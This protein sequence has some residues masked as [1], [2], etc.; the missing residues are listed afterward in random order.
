M[1]VVDLLHQPLVVGS[2]PGA[3]IEIKMRDDIAEIDGTV[4]DVASS[5]AMAAGNATASSSPRAWVYCVPLPD[6]PGQFQHLAVSGEGRFDSSTMAP[7]DYRVLAFANRQPNLPYRDAEA[8]RAYETKGQVI[9]LAPGQKAT[10]Q[11]QIISSI[12]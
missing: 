9:H 8:M 5:A 4:T 1:G 6:S 3:P 11:V 10:V 12:Q 7:G 2:G